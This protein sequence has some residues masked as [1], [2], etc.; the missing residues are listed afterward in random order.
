MSDTRRTQAE[1]EKLKNDVR[2]L[3]RAG[4]SNKEIMAKL[5]L[6]NSDI[7]TAKRALGI[8]CRTEEEAESGEVTLR[9]KEYYDA[10]FVPTYADTAKE[11][12]YTDKSGH[13]Y[14]DVSEFFGL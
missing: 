11:R 8:Y 9:V 1:M 10:K 2:V 5:G 7:I 12:P 13:K 3:V 6:T 4:Y 14:T